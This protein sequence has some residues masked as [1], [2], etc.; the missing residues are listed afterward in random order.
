MKEFPRNGKKLIQHLYSIKVIEKPV[1]I[2]VSR[3]QCMVGFW[4][5]K[6]RSV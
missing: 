6:Y 5:I 4:E 1:K 3:E 2:I